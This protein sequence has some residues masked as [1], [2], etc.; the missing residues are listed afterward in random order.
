MNCSGIPSVCLQARL[1]DP[2][3]QNYIRANLSQQEDALLNDI[4]TTCVCPGKI[5]AY[6][7]FKFCIR[8]IYI[9]I[10]VI[11]KLQLSQQPGCTFSVSRFEASEFQN[12]M[13][14]SG[15]YLSGLQAQSLYLRGPPS[16]NTVI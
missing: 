14:A 3:M 16:K 2:A 10:Y 15:R 13:E 4:I 8:C 1:C 6:N 11:N 12:E 7:L 9:Y 5:Y